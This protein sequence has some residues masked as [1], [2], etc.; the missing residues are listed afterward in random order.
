MQRDIHALRAVRR[1][2]HGS[3]RVHGVPQA[4]FS[5]RERRAL[6]PFQEGLIYRVSD[7]SASVCSTTGTMVV[8]RVSG[9]KGRANP[10]SALNMGDRLF[11]PLDRLK[12]ARRTRVK[13]T[14][15]S[16]RA[17]RE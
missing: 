4:L 2:T 10:L 8:R 16:L 14:P 7:T 11:T 6:H 12:T 9:A 1:G 13:Y 5:G 3:E 15:S 17:P